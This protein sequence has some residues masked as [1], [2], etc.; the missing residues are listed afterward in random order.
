MKSIEIKKLGI[1]INTLRKWRGLTQEDLAEAM[2]VS[3]G[4][5]SLMENGRR[6]P[7]VE[8]CNAIAKALN[9]DVVVLMIL[10]SRVP[11]ST[12]ES[13]EQWAVRTQEAVFALLEADSATKLAIQT[14]QQGQSGGALES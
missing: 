4:Y 7:T 11:Q 3:V 6:A 8:T 12:H 14:S 5:I 9:I 2:N 1:A 13:L 10:G